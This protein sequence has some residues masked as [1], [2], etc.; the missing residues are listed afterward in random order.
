MKRVIDPPVLYV[1]PDFWIDPE[2]SSDIRND[3]IVSA[4]SQEDQAHRQMAGAREGHQVFLSIG[5]SLEAW[6]ARRRRN[7]QQAAR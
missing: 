1:A 4:K 7:K 2:D 3:L 6:K 5:E